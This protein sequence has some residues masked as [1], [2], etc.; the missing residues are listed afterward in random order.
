[1]L[2]AG[3]IVILTSAENTMVAIEEGMIDWRNCEEFMKGWHASHP[4]L[5][6]PMLCLSDSKKEV[7]YYRFCT[8]AIIYAFYDLQKLVAQVIILRRPQL[9]H[10]IPQN[11]EAM[12]AVIADV[13]FI[14][15]TKLPEPIF[16]AA[17]IA[18]VEQ[19]GA[20]GGVIVV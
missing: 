14:I 10:P 17:D 9:L 2:S 11:I 20:S 8:A 13:L 12:R 15:S 4:L 6:R 3:D 1:M 19:E 16:F 7:V 5:G 18:D